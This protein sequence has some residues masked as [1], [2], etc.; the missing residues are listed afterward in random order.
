[1]AVDRV[2]V[3]FAPLVLGQ[4]A[5]L[6]QDRGCNTHFP[7]IVELGRIAQLT[8]IVEVLT[9]RSGEEMTLFV[10]REHMVAGALVVYLRGTREQGYGHSEGL[11]PIIIQTR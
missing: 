5:G 8:A 7:D 1:M 3:H 10:D 2:V 6:S 11:V 9:K 4:R